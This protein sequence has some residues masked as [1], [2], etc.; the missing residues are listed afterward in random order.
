MQL[1]KKTNCI[2]AKSSVYAGGSINLITNLSK[3]IINVDD[4]VLQET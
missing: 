2:N 1:Q 3:I 4:E